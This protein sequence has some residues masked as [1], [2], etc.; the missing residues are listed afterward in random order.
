MCVSSFQHVKCRGLARA[1]E[2][3][4]DRALPE[5]EEAFQK[6]EEEGN[7]RNNR[8]LVV[9]GH[10]MGGGAASLAAMALKADDRLVAIY[11][12]LTFFLKKTFLLRGLGLA[13]LEAVSLASPPSFRRDNVTDATAVGEEAEQTDFIHTYVLGQDCVPRL[14]MATISR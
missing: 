6:L 4:L 14:S 2:T 8:R 5:L 10:S 9:T 13:D 3:L 7:S 12:F 11:N 1:V